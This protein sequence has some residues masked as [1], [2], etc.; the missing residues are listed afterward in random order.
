MASSGDAAKIEFVGEVRDVKDKVG[1][2]EIAF[3]RLT[4]E[5]QKT[6]KASGEASRQKMPVKEAKDMASAF[7]EGALQLGA[8]LIGLEA[9][10]RA[11]IAVIDAQERAANKGLA[12]VDRMA[13]LASRLGARNTAGIR[14]QVEA[15]S[16]GTGMT[17]DQS[18]EVFERGRTADSSLPASKSMARSA[19]FGRMADDAKIGDAGGFVEAGMRMMKSDPSLNEQQAGELAFQL[20][21]AGVTD[22]GGYMEQF[23]GNA[24]GAVTAAV[25]AQRAGQDPGFVSNMLGKMRGAQKVGFA[26][27]DRGDRFLFGPGGKMKDTADLLLSGQVPEDFLA[28]EMTRGNKSASARAFNAALGGAGADVSRGGML[29]AQITQNKNDP[30]IV[31]QEAVDDAKQAAFWNEYDRGTESD[32]MKNQL[33][34]ERLKAGM[35]KNAITGAVANVPYAANLINA[36]TS[37]LAGLT[38]LTPFGS[39]AGQSIGAPVDP[40]WD[41]AQQ[42]MRHVVRSAPG[43]QIDVRVRNAGEQASRDSY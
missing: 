22:V 4:K 19:A 10:R 31:M 8:Q 7:K 39:G 5:I 12:A 43:M 15:F 1:Q 6:A 35:Q 37:A 29:A 41:M 34:V 20:Q 18:L 26:K 33:N 28:G 11:V 2:L 13:Q 27:A 38:A 23:P 32:E 17:L 30:T 40:Q 25:A 36:Q 24:R 21:M 9:V 14:D 16:R 3:G 42:A